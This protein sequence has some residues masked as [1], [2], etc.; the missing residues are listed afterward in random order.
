MSSSPGKLMQVGIAD[1]AA[2][3]LGNTGRTI[4][5]IGTAQSGAASITVNSALLTTAGGATA[6]V[7]ATTWE[8]QDDVTVFN[9]SATTALL[10]P[11]SGGAFNGGSTDASI[12]IAQ[13]VGVLLRKVS[14]TSWRAIASNAGTGTA[15]GD[16]TVDGITGTD[17]SLG[18]TGLAAAQG[19][20]VALTGGASLT[21]AN[22]GGAVTATGG[23]A[24]ATGVGGA[25]TLTAA[26]GGATSG[27][28]GAGSLTAGAG[29]AGNS[30]GGVG[31]VT[32]GA[33]QGSAAGGIA[34]AVGGAGGATGAGGAAQLTGGAGGA[35]SGTGGAATITGGAGTN[36]NAVGG[37]ASVT[38]GAG[39]GTG[40]GGAASLIGGASGA[41]ATGN[42]AAANVTG[43]AA[44]STNGS[45]GSVV[46]TGGAK[47][48]TGIAGGVRTEGLDVVTMSAPAAK[49][50]SAT[51]TAAEILGGLLTANQGAAGAAT[52]TMPLGTDLAAALP[53]DFATGDTFQFSIINIST[54]SAE[55]VTV[56][57]NTGTTAVGNMTIAANNATTN[58]AWGT[59]RVRQ[60]GAAAYSFYRVG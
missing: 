22:A 29:T 46:L 53:A 42:G 6:F 28:G 19:G 31:S 44:L 38:A 54:N 39:N 49:T 21:S 57:G 14:A 55:I 35:T 50:T 11:Q 58:Q 36:G 10:Y 24:G 52:Y 60:T 32:G 12:S 51:L 13:N 47:T 2:I 16:I 40:T 15:F 8:V 33:G 41:G 20:A 18:I 27:T 25:V 56:A 23:A 3:L 17:A 37:A 26:A 5:G 34:R 43:G 30:A 9:T 45:G 48:G 4:A 7:L 59:F 1:K